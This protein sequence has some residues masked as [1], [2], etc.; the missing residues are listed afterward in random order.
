MS[1]LEILD[2]SV[3]NN[4]GAEPFVAALIDDTYDGKVKLVIMFKEE[5]CTAV[6]DLDMLIEE[7]DISGKKHHQLGSKYE[8][9]LRDLLWE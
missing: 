5:G 3:H 1:E 2:S 4:V 6:L 9:L 8:S 7:E